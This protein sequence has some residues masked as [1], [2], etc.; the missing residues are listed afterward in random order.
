MLDRK[1]IFVVIDLA[2]DFVGLIK[3]NLA[4]TKIVGRRIEAN[5]EVFREQVC[6]LHLIGAIGVNKDVGERGR[7]VTN[8]TA[9]VKHLQKITYLTVDFS[10]L[11]LA[12]LGIDRSI[13]GLVI[14]QKHW[15]I[16]GVTSGPRAMLLEPFEEIFQRA[17]VLL[18]HEDCRLVQVLE[19]HPNPCSHRLVEIAE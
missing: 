18:D 8:V 6:P 19:G 13:I 12:V 2:N 15:R 17:G 4:G 11:A 9:T 7:R 1:I 3:K 5:D 14:D 10:N 16:D